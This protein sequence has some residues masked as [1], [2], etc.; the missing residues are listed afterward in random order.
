[1]RLTCEDCGSVFVV[2]TAERELY[3]SRAVLKW[4]P[5]CCRSCRVRRREEAVML[6]PSED[7]DRGDDD[8]D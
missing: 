3:E 6:L 5:T 2:T 4:R 8:G 1:M 7:A